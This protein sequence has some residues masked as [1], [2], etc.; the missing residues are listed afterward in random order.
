[1]FVAHR[2]LNRY[3]HWKLGVL[4][5]MYVR[6]LYRWYQPL[7]KETCIPQG[8]LKKLI[9]HYRRW[10]GHS[11]TDINTGSQKD[12]VCLLKEEITTDVGGWWRT[13]N[14]KKIVFCYGCFLT[15]VG[16]ELQRML[17]WNQNYFD[18]FKQSSFAY[19]SVLIWY[20]LRSFSGKA[21]FRVESKLQTPAQVL[22][23]RLSVLNKVFCASGFAWRVLAV[24]IISPPWSSCPS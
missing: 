4:Y 12:G 15:C 24:N 10:V 6:W 22:E 18:Y 13:G 7:F 9:H 8:T 19:F 21:M 1:M 11:E 17:P 20:H 2:Y 14:W 23:D 3:C 16:C 5:L